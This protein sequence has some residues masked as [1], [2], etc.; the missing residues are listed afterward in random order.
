MTIWDWKYRIFFQTEVK[1]EVELWLSKLNEEERKIYDSI[2]SFYSSFY[3]FGV[4]FD[5]VCEDG[6]DVKT[7]LGYALQN[8]N[9]IIQTPLTLVPYYKRE[10]KASF[11]DAQIR[12]ELLQL[13]NLSLSAK[14][15]KT[16]YWHLVATLL[17]NSHAKI[18]NAFLNEQFSPE[19][20]R[21]P[22]QHIIS[23]VTDDTFEKIYHS[24]TASSKL[25]ERFG[26]NAIKSFGKKIT[27]GNGY[28]EWWDRE[29]SET[30]NDELVLYTNN[31]IVKQE[32]YFYTIIHET[33]P[34]HGHFFNAVCHNG[35]LM[36]HGAMMLTEGWATYCEWNTIPS[37]YVDVIRHNAL[38][39]L[40][41]SF[42]LDCNTRANLIYKRKQRQGLRV[43]QFINSLIYATQYVGYLESYYLGALWIE[44]AITEKYGTPMNFLSMLASSNKGEFFKL[45][46]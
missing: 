5:L 31:D 27:T 29:I 39:F 13:L 42:S 25:N 41:N 32:D 3:S 30:G 37:K 24:L 2:V 8:S 44:K 22:T 40:N 7:I 1:Q 6:A 36:D 35:T 23:G 14:E 19:P 33:Y 43:T 26:N 10:I 45:W 38:V 18:F 28:G 16:E 46:L 11:N 21:R 12:Q 15:N 9:K 34:G 20:L 17:G 4:L